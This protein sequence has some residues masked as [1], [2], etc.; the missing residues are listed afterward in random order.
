LS[1]PQIYSARPPDTGEYPELVFGFI[2]ALGTD[3]DTLYHALELELR[4]VGYRSHLIHVIE[5]VPGYSDKVKSSDAYEQM[6]QKIV[7]GTDFRQATGRSDI[8][9]A[10]AVK[11]IRRIRSQEN[12]QTAQEE[13]KSVKPLQK[14]AYTIR[15]L[16][17]P[18]EVTALRKTYGNGLY[19]ISAYSSYDNR[20]RKIAQ[21]L[22]GMIN[23]AD[24]M[25]E[26]KE[27]IE[28]DA[29]EEDKGEF[30]Q[31]VSDTFPLAD[32]FINMDKDSG[33]ISNDIKR[34]V[35]LIFR[36]TITPTKEEFAMFQ[37]FASALRSASLSR[38]VGAAI[39]TSEGDILAVG[40]NEVPKPG[41][42]LYWE[43]DAAKERD[44]ERGYD[45]SQRSREEIFS[46]IVE[47]LQKKGLITQPVGKEALKA[48][49]AK[50]LLL[51]RIDLSRTVH[52]EM[53]ALLSAARLGVK[54]DGGTLY[55]TTFPCHDCSKHIVAA[56]ITDV[57]YIEPYAKSLVS[58]FYPDSI[59]IDEKEDAT[60][61][62]KKVRFRPFIGISPSRY[63]S[64]FFMKHPLSI[65]KRDDDQGNAI[66]PKSGSWEWRPRFGVDPVTSEDKENLLIATFAEAFP[67]SKVSSQ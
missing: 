54:I 65:I 36:V 53:A 25:I 64:F 22:G 56:G 40:A 52:A 28:T 13:Q 47:K 50:S 44:Y 48:I 58:E 6:K 41:G 1:K 37:S 19:L 60:N 31:Q 34:F 3:L 43:D 10:I 21:R 17:T 61:S 57:V 62:G 59:A 11:E 5:S 51:N 46:D 67:E 55:S 29:K 45:T 26:A 27:L 9:A 4:S 30:G 33:T 16:K 23:F 32:F 15:Q 14:V 38:Q 12:K 2:A 35:R 8:F 49:N 20:L 42:G 7:L 24:H 63:V 66:T 18:T 39:G